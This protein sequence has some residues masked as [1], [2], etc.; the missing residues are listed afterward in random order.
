MGRHRLFIA[1]V[2]TFSLA[3]AFAALADLKPEVQLGA[4][5]V[6][7]AAAE[8]EDGEA[9]E[10]VADFADTS[11]NVG[12]RQKLYGD[13]RGRMVVG[14]Q[15]PEA[16]SALGPVFFDQVF[17]KVEDKSNAFTIG[18]SRVASTLQ[19]FPTIRDDDAL[20]YTDVLNPSTGDDSRETQYG[21]TVRL[22]HVFSQRWWVTGHGEHMAAAPPAELTA[23]AVD[24]GF[25][26]GGASLVYAVPESQRWNRQV[27]D[28]VGVGFFGYYVDRP[29]YERFVDNTAI[30]ALATVTLNVCPD[31]VHFTDLRHQSIYNPG[32]AEVTGAPGGDYYSLATAKSYAAFTTLRYLYRRYERPSLQASVGF[33]YKTFPDFEDET[34]QMLALANLF[35]RLGAGFDVVVQYRYERFTGDLAAMRGDGRH[36]LELGLV[37]SVEQ[38][39]NRQFD[40]RDSLLNLEH[41]YI[42]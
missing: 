12:F 22:S 33:G 41:G 32:F 39:W 38:S 37:Y 2:S 17:L 42:P 3:A 7:N 35:Y 10:A 30:N 40:D 24:Y 26:A 5:A 29:N 28:R 6:I 9:A 25:N 20:E 13:F 34:D 4:R 15:F 19:E 31:P 16:G 23:A 14:F 36:A 1:F 11:L 18:R 8:V 21:E 27:V